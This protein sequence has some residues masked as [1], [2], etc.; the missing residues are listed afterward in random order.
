MDIKLGK[1][2]KKIRVDISTSSQLQFLS[3]SGIGTSNMYGLFHTDSSIQQSLFSVN[4]GLP[5][6][7]IFPWLGCFRELWPITLIFC[8][9]SSSLFKCFGSP[10]MEASSLMAMAP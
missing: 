10:L 4:S 3:Y 5:G 1:V 6:S 7:A 9:L 8:K 2:V